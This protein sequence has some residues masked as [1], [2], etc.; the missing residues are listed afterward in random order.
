MRSKA[1]KSLL[2]CF[3]LCSMYSALAAPLSQVEPLFQDLDWDSFQVPIHENGP[4]TPAVGLRSFIGVRKDGVEFSLSL[5][6][7]TDL[8]QG[9]WTGLVTAVP[10]P[11]FKLQ[12]L[13][14]DAVYAVKT[15]GA[16]AEGPDAES[17]GGW[18][19]GDS[20][21]ATHAVI[22]DIEWDEIKKLTESDYLRVD[23]TTIEDPDTS[24]VV[25]ISLLLFQ[26]KIQALEDQ[27]A[28]TDEGKKFFLTK[29]EAMAIP[30]K[31]LPESMRAGPLKK[32][33]ERSSDFFKL[34]ATEVM[35]FSVSELTAKKEAV[36]EK[37]RKNVLAEKK[38][39]YQ[40]IYDQEPKWL[41][42]NI[43]PR[44]DVTHC[45]SIGK[46]AYAQPDIMLGSDFTYGEIIG[47]VWRSAGS[48]VRIYGGMVDYDIEPKI[49]RASE[50]EYYFIVRNDEDRVDIRP[51]NYVVVRPN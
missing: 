40:A 21:V 24:H 41:D 31:D 44:S 22:F 37:L 6:T 1:I 25:D 43:C 29:A 20:T 48:I 42:M 33:I 35:Q 19:T 10:R 28:T 17:H 14:K 13:T 26:E 4:E 45:S 38:K 39:A 8:K 23:Y 36:D 12:R 3:G 9:R 5:A 16:R 34:T 47:V 7:S 30:I 50:A 46:T 51:C 32:L 18:K 49:H 2:V 27:F 11:Q 15:T